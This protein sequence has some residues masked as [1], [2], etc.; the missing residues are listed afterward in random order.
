MIPE[1]I[2][3]KQVL[4]AI[5]EVKRTGIPEKRNSKKFLIKFEDGYFPPKFVISLANKYANGEELNPAGFS[6]G[7]ES[8]DFLRA[9]GFE[10]FDVKSLERTFSRAS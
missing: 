7:R 10:I 6:G 2:E 9:L 1:N 4:Q 5:E 3:R 8:N